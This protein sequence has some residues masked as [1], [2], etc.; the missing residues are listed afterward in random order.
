MTSS[1]WRTWL[2]HRSLPAPHALRPERQRRVVWCW[3]Q[4]EPRT[5]LAADLSINN[6]SVVEP[7][8]GNTNAV[9]TVTLSEASS[10]PVTVNYNTTDGVAVAGADYTA[11]SGTLTFAPGTTSQTVSIPVLG[12]ETVP[13]ND[14]FS[15]NLSNPTGA[16]IA[17][18]GGVGTGTILSASALSIN[19]VTVVEGT[20]GTTNAV[21]TVTLDPP[22]IEE[23][24]TV[25]YSTQDGTAKA[26]VDY[27]AVSGTLTF[28]PDQTS[29]NIL[30][31][32]INGTTYKPTEMF[33]VNLSN[34][35]NAIIEKGQGTGTIVD[36]NT[37][38]SMQFSSANYNVAPSDGT[39]TITVT[40]TSGTASDVGISYATS[41]GTAVAG[42]DYTPVSG[43]LDFAANQTSK[44]F[45]IPILSNLLLGG[46]K[47]VGLTLTQPTGG[48]T[49][50]SQSTA[51][52]TISDPN[53]L[54][55]SNTNDSGAGSLRQAMLTANANPGG[56]T[57]TFDVP[58]GGPFTIAPTSELPLLTV[59]VTIDGTTQPGYQGAPLVELSGANAGSQVNG[60]SITVGNTT[61]KGLAINRF[62]GSGILLQ[63][64]G[65]N[66]I[67]A[68]EIGT[69]VSG[70]AALGNAFDGIAINDSSNNIIGGTNASSRNVISGNGITG[71]Q[72]TGTSSTGNIIEGNYIGTDRTGQKDLGNVSGGIYLF[73]VSGNT[74]GGSVTGAG[75]VISGNDGSGVQITGASA[76]QN[77][78]QGNLIGTDATGAKALGNVHDGIYVESAPNNTIGGT[79][80]SQANVISGNQ[81]TGIRI[82]GTSATGNQVEGNR[83]G[84]DQT[85]EKAVGN[86]YD[87]IF[88]NGAPGNTIGGLTTGAGNQISG[89]G[90]VG[91]QIYSTASTGNLVQG[92]LI[93]TDATGLRALGN[94]HDGVY[95]N[96]ASN[97]T[98]GGTANGSR[99]IISG[100][101][102]V[103][104]QLSPSGATGNVIQGNFIGTNINGRP[105][106]G[107]AYGIF[108]DGA[109][110]NTIGGPG[111]QAN[112][113]AGNRQA[114]VLAGSSTIT[115]SGKTSVRAAATALAVQQANLNT[116]G[117]QVTSVTLNFSAPLNTA[118]AQDI[119]NYRLRMTG[120]SGRSAPRSATS[121]PLRSATYDPAS[122][123]VT[124]NLVA[125]LSLGV[126]F[127]LQ[128]NGKPGRGLTDASGN[129]LSG[130]SYVT[131]LNDAG[132]TNSQSS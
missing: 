94:V 38:G 60:L 20:S 36:S 72:V 68:D 67:L 114:N 48:G 13:A 1:S 96:E 84:T 32:I 79:E 44:T 99:N 75:N 101:H 82:N 4:C 120:T 12:G 30:V 24:V 3:E 97:N 11:E 9:F 31:P 112:L 40:R 106:L 81:L 47:T 95:V 109:T 61:I 41:G 59:P 35:T 29:Q 58:G 26:G 55:V 66:Q 111:A 37:P 19:D 27:E 123:S 50:G 130:R 85:G 128:V 10:Q 45:T 100:N 110:G 119:S 129:Y 43:T 127:Q 126:S 76:S 53:T 6:V 83:I 71:V 103:G 17:P 5:L 87:G 51:T 113:V 62:S 22:N 33:S 56:K 52:L 122:N 23:P 28:A 115:A 118:R 125:P 131:T 18:N 78:I 108:L 102:I 105:Q 89:N 21:F 92:N 7:S 69:N 2:N 80:A 77:I 49:L 117:S 90:G 42:V 70:T 46:S 64:G 16:A 65:S 8:S 25:D 34:A 57:I 54:V 132:A 91:V 14:T 98:I 104:V 74:V 73:G 39:A 63:G 93:G 124:L 88:V 121:I 86:T 107:N 15:V 116:S